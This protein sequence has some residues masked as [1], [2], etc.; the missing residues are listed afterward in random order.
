MAALELACGGLIVDGDATELPASVERYSDPLFSSSVVVT[1]FSDS[2]WDEFSMFSSLRD[3]ILGEL[4]NASILP[5]FLGL[6]SL[7]I[8]C[9]EFP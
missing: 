7:S 1:D 4:E 5:V 8:S 2:E 6:Y 3:R 9:I